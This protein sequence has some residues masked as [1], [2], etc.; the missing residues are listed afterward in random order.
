MAIKNKSKS[1]PWDIVEKAIAKEIK[2]LKE[3]IEASPFV[4]DKLTCKDCI[5]RNI[6]ILILTGKVKAKDIKSSISLFGRK[7]SF[8]IIK[9]HGGPEH[10][11]T[12]KLVAT[13]FNTLGYDVV[14]EPN[15]NWG[16]ADLGVYKK[17]KR[18]LF[19]EVGT[20]SLQKLLLNLLSMKEA[21]FL[22]V[23]DTNHA[24]EFSVLEIEDNHRLAIR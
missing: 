1:L 8:P 13:Y 6:A 10:F 19:I 3:T 20:I 21:D 22:L 23:L 11:E 9:S 12:M 16:R 7:R 4:E 18:N 15:L 14:A 5:F 2:W 17:G 24:V